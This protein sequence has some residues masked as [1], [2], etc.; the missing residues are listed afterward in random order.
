MKNN[1]TS[2][3][4]QSYLV[5]YVWAGMTAC[6]LTA[7]AT[8]A[9]REWTDRTNQLATIDEGRLECLAQTLTD[10]QVRFVASA[11]PVSGE[12][13]QE[14]QAL[15]ATLIESDLPAFSVYSSKILA[16]ERA[17]TNA[18]VGLHYG[19]AEPVTLRLS[20]IERVHRE[21]ADM[22]LSAGEAN[23]V[24]AVL[25]ETYKEQL[26][27]FI[28]AVRQGYEARHQAE[29]QRRAQS[30]Q[31]ATAILG[32]YGTSATP[33][34]T[35]AYTPALPQTSYNT[36]HMCFKSGESISGMNKICYYNCLGSTAAMTIGS[37]ELCPLS[38]R[39]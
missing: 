36:G 25:A 10:P 26:P 5:K 20:I 12:A 31:T 15:N 21:L 38:Q 4:K 16:C 32:A 2:E 22:T 8:A 33:S 1:E 23:K 35:T 28:A 17:Y 19:F 7:C 27:N 13:S 11:F 37:I 14:Q 6:L 24:L 34:A 18:M 9:Q 3:G 30:L 39:F 29:I